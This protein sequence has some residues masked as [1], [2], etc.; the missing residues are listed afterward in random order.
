MALAR[1]VPLSLVSTTHIRGPELLAR[2]GPRSGRCGP[3]A[4]ASRARGGRLVATV[5][6]GLYVGGFTPRTL[7]RNLSGS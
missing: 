4:H 2:A 7:L 5:D 3:P 1:P 6:S